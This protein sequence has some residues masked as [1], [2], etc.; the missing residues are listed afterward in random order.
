MIKPNKASATPLNISK[1]ILFFHLQAELLEFK[2]F[3]HCRLCL[4]VAGASGFES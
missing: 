2:P 3:A 1:P 4:A